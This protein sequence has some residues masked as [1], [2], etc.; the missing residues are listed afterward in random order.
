MLNVF[1]GNY[2]FTNEFLWLLSIAFLPFRMCITD[3]NRYK[4]VVNYKI[5]Y[6]GFKK[7]KGSNEIFNSRTHFIVEKLEQRT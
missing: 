5:H 3:E 2:V 4:F 7:I 6:I 1:E